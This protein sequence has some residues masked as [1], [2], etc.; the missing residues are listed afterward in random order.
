MGQ[1]R[2]IE[3][4]ILSL[5]AAFKDSD[6][7]AILLMDAKNAFNSLNRDL[8][9]RNIKNLCPFIYHFICKSYR[10]PSKL[11]LTNKQYSLRKAQPL[12]MSMYG[13]VIIHHFEDCSRIQKWYADH[14]NDVGSL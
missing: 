8:A 3:H 10:E 9:L 6:S 14:D 5:R 4:A 7:E 12:A 2:G 13:I 1:K 11:L